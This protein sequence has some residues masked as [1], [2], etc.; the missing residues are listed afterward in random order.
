M[1]NLNFQYAWIILLVLIL[2]SNA[3]V[4]QVTGQLDLTDEI[5]SPIDLT[6]PPGTNALY[7]RVID[8]DN[9]LDP[10]GIDTL[11]VFFYSPVEQ[12]G[13]KII[14]YESGNSTNE[15]RGSIETEISS[16]GTLDGKLQLMQGDSI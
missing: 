1:T 15:F 6:Y 9:N 13:E 3:T 5:Y 4:A 10:N 8:P 11:H 7:A 16:N 14:F 2:L 12:Y